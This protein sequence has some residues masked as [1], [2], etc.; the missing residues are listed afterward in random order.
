MGSIVAIG[1]G[2]IR[3]LATEPLDREIVL[4]TGKSRPHAL[5]VPTASSDAADYAPVFDRVYG[6]RLGCTTDVLYLLGSTPDPQVV[7]ERSTARTSSTW[8][9]AIRS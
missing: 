1:G 9:A 4:L 6:A 5:L 3:T 7:R 8:A 2:A